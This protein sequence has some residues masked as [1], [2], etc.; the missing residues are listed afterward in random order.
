M[1]FSQERALI[2]F[3]LQPNHFRELD[4]W[5]N[6]LLV[7]VCIF[8]TVFS[9]FSWGS[10]RLWTSTSICTSQRASH[11][12]WRHQS[13]DASGKSASKTY[14]ESWPVVLSALVQW[15][16]SSTSTVIFVLQFSPLLP[17]FSKFCYCLLGEMGPLLSKKEGHKYVFLAGAARVE[18]NVPFLENRVGAVRLLGWCR[19]A[20]CSLRPLPIDTVLMHLKRDMGSASTDTMAN[21]VATKRTIDVF[22]VTEVFFC[23]FRVGRGKLEMDR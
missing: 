16:E 22:I 21:N 18:T 5:S 19:G 11:L 13:Y 12:S 2:I 23:S 14:F 6:V 4:S 1:G 7:S 3:H 8:T 15:C 9:F 20:C 17:Q 10:G